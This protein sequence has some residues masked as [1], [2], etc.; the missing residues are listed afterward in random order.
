MTV[1]VSAGRNAI[2]RNFLE[3][4][5][6]WLW[7]IDDDMVFESDI[8]MRL[9]ANKVD[10]V[11]AL[12]LMRVPPHNATMYMGP[13]PINFLYTQKVLTD[14]MRLV[15]VDACGTGGMLIRRRVLEVLGSPWFDVGHIGTGALG[16]DIAFCEK[17]KAHGFGVFVDT[18]TPA[19]HITPVEI[20]PLR[21]PQ[22]NEEWTT[23]VKFT[24]QVS[25]LIDAAK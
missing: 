7:F 11:Q 25:L 10:I 2:V 23:E 13:D 9:L 18:T 3:T 19:G 20:W 8:L 6:D 24:S 4:D 1:D 12:T 14:E 15:E 16:E 17:A 5:G 22:K 21:N